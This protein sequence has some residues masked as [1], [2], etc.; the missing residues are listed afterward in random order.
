[1]SEAQRL[2]LLAQLESELQQIR[3]EQLAYDAIKQRAARADGL[4][5]FLPQAE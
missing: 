2:A 4:V 1:M 5:F 3:E